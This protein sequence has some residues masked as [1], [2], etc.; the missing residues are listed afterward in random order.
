[1]TEFFKKSKKLY[2]GTIWPFFPSYAK[3]NFPGE[4]GSVSF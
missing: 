3:M 2:C 4:K 1:M